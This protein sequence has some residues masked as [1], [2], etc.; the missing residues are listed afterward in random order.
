MLKAW[1][2]LVIWT[3]VNKPLLSAFILLSLGFVLH[4]MFALSISARSFK[5]L[6]HPFLFTILT[7]GFLKYSSQKECVSCSNF[8]C[9]PLLLYWSMIVSWYDCKVWSWG[10]FYNLMIKFPSFSGPISHGCYV[11]KCFSICT[12]FFLSSLLHP[13]APALTIYFLESLNSVDYVFTL[14]WDRQARGSWDQK[15]SLYPNG[16][17]LW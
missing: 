15:N 2:I 3:K 8:R 12:T 13:L 9:N 10:D 5:Y 7:L 1:N 4:F 16:V 11:Q 17:R 14:R 6:S